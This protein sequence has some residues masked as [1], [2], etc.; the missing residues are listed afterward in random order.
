MISLS[1]IIKAAGYVA[2][3][4]IKQV[5]TARHEFTANQ[6][7]GTEESPDPEQPQHNETIQ[8]AEETA[9]HIIE[10]AQMER[11][12]IR[13]EA[14]REIEAW[15]QKRR[16]ED[17]QYIE[18]LKKQGYDEGYAAGRDQAE[19]DVHEQYSGKLKEAETIIQSGYELKSSILD[20]A[21]P[22]L[23]ELSTAIAEKII[24]HQLEETTSWLI[25]LVKREL[26]RRREQ[27]QI[28][29]CVAPEYFQMI[30]DVRDELKMTIDSQAELSIVPDANIQ[31]AGCVIR[32]AFGSVDATIDTQLT[33]IK[34][35][36][37]QLTQEHKGINSYE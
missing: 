1:N 31:S 16:E 5:E 18:D 30:L 17:S 14:D 34:A 29:L 13:K 9:Q 4:D 8:S 19:H 21:E 36:L 27:G 32:S 7:R 33:E 2:L 35:S 20:E 28:T 11:E 10:N 24:G 3:D 23:L 15:W 26:S 25:E 6:L 37:L 22:F 12:S